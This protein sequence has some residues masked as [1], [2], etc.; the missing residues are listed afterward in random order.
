LAAGFLLPQAG[1]ILFSGTAVGAPDRRRLL[2]YQEQD[3][4]FPWL[5]L[6]AN[7]ALPLV[8]GAEGCSRA[9]A[10]ERAREALVQ[11]GLGDRLDAFPHQL[12]GG[13]KQRAV[14]A[15]ALAV[16][17][18]LLLLDE[19]FASLDAFSRESLQELLVRAW[20]QHGSTVVF[21]T[22]DLREALRIGGEIRFLHPPGGTGVLER[23]AVPGAPLRD[24]ETPE[25]V[26]L[27]RAVRRRF[28]LGTA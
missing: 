14:L 24:L 28:E 16:R 4:L 5:R 3:Q 10:D 21:V 2:I 12:S 8:W 22:H 19:P 17:S 20:R 23:I 25:A 26:A 7:T 6:L 11:V 9:D 13:M 1:S 18:P 15:R 27:L